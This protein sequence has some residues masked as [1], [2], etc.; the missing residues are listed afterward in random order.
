MIEQKAAPPKLSGGLKM[1]KQLYVILICF[2]IS[3]AFWLL[4]ALSHDYPASLSFPVE[5]KNLP[6]R[7][8]LMN[9]M[10][11]EISIQVKTT[12]FRLISYGFQKSNPVVEIDVASSLRPP[13]TG[14]DIIAIPTRTFLSDFAKE[15]GKDVTITGFSPDSIVFNFSDIVTRSIPVIL[16]LKASYEKQYDST[17]SP[18][19]YPPFI[20]VSGPPALISRLNS[21]QTES[22]KLENLKETVR[23]KVKLVENRLL[24]YSQNEVEFVLPVEKYT[25]GVSEIEV[26]PVNVRDGFSLK[27]FPDKIKV[28]YLV[29]LSQYS[30]VD[31]SMFDA[32]V[33]GSE[34]DVKRPSKLGVS[35]I[36]SPSFVRVTMLEPEKVDY[37]LRKQ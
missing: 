27:T 19:V 30:K 15:L 25:E 34:L 35:I 14:T 18:K 12:G 17:G 23:R 29:A 36:T 24:T 33:D 3:M 21:I 20:Q 7:K 8:V 4:L 31:N 26:H 37:I 6:G 1:N 16:S 2:L 5:Y 32:V 10:P 22:V 28:R 11:K 13:A 9:E